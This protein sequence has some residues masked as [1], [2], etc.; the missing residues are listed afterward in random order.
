[1][2]E[3]SPLSEIAWFQEKYSKLINMEDF[4]EDIQVLCAEFG[5]ETAL[6]MIKMFGGQAVYFKS[7]DLA[8]KPVRDKIIREQ[9]NDGAGYKDLAKEFGLSVSYVRR[10]IDEN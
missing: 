4:S 8:L 2:S 10:I 6:R 3:H 1:M 5:L 7:L 9:F